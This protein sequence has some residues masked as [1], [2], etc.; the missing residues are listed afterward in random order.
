MLTV[1][2]NYKQ[3]CKQKLESRR[4]AIDWLGSTN[5]IFTNASLITS[6]W[7]IINATSNNCVFVVKMME[8]RILLHN[9]LKISTCFFW[10]DK[11]SVFIHCQY[12]VDI[13][14]AC[15]CVSS[16][17]WTSL[18]TWGFSPAALQRWSRRRRRSWSAARSW[19]RLP[20]KTRWAQLPASATTCWWTANGSLFWLFRKTLGEKATVL[21]LYWMKI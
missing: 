5:K 19:L 16:V 4:L 15:V 1:T 10:L 7:C 17:K 21:L 2:S 18:W 6:I 14:R 12:H 13:N 20:R 11:N 8:P 9:C 3:N